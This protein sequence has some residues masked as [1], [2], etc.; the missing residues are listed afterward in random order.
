MLQIDH[1]VR[2]FVFQYAEAE[3]RYLLLRQKPRSEWPMGPVVGSVD[4]G[5]H[6]QDA[7]LREVAETT[8]F[9]RP[10]QLIDLARP[11]KE[12]FGEMGLVEWPF[13]WQA[14]SPDEPAETIV[15]GPRVAEFAW[16]G[17]DEAFEAVETDRDR[18][19]LVRIQLSLENGG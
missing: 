8:G 2:V 17:F 3:I 9:R 1:R 15:P 10:Q 6:L 13:A 12:L 5:D 11:S 7:I 14:G 4:L 16:L 18:D 19:D